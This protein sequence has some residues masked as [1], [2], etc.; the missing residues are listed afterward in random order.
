V[1]TVTSSPSG[2]NCDTSC[3]VASAG[4][5]KNAQ[6]TLT[7]TADSSSTFVGWSG[8]GCSGTGTCAVTLVFGAETVMATF[9]HM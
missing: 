9:Q 4:F 1:E 8:G 5:A 6:V 2:I 7:A 3:Q